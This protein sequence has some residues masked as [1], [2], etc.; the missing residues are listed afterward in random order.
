MAE[1]SG[2]VRTRGQLTQLACVSSIRMWLGPGAWVNVGSKQHAAGTVTHA[3]GGTG[4]AQPVSWLVSL[5][6][7]PMDPSPRVMNSM[8]VYIYIYIYMILLIPFLLPKFL[9]TINIYN[10][11]D[12][13]NCGF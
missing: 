1:S 5:G 2:L 10:C 9:D 3:V 13:V 11:G 12:T 7:E 4:L 6:D 8:C